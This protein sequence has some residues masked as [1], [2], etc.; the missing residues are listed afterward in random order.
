MPEPLPR[1]PFRLEAGARQIAHDVDAELEFHLAMRTRQLIAAGLDP[2]AARAQAE[3]LFGNLPAVRAQCLTIDHAWER[4]VTRANQLDNLRQDATH[5][6]RGLRHHPGFAAVLLLI[7]ALGIGA[8]T[9]MFSLIDVLMRRSLPVPRPAQLVGVGDQRR[10]G[11]LSTG[12]PRTDL[13]S[14]PLYRDLR[15]RNRVVTGLYA[16]GRTGGL[17]VVIAPL[18]GGSTAGAEPEHPRGRL[19]SGNF[20]SVLQVPAQ[21]GRTFTADEDQSPLSDPVVV[22][23]Y[24]YWQRRFGGEPGVLGRRLTINGAPLTIIGV[25][26]AGFTGDLVGQPTDIWIPLMMQPAIMPHTTWLTDRS[27]GWLLLMGRLAPGV[28]LPQARAELRRLAGLSIKENASAADLPSIERDLVAR[29]VPVESGARGFSYYRSQ[30]A[31][32]LLTLLS[33]VG[34]VLLVVCANVATMM[35]ARAEGRSREMSVRMALGAGRRRLVQQMLTESVILAAAGGALGLVVALW[36]SAALLRLAGGGT[37]IPLD[38]RLDGRM[39]GITAMLSLLTAVLFGLAPALRAT[40]IEVATALRAQGRGVAGA[41]SRPGRIAFGKL[42]VMSQVALSLLLLV[43]TGMLLRSL[44]RLEHTDVGLAR[45]SLVIARVDAERA[46]YA[47]PRLLALLRDLPGQVSQVPGVAGVSM[48]ENGIFSGTESSTTLQVEGFVARVPEDTAANY[49]DVGPGYF[50]TVGAHLLSG[51]DFAVQDN[52]SGP[53]VAVVNQTMARFYFPAGG[54]LGR[55]VTV[56]SSSFEIVGV[57]ADILGRD[58]RAEPTRRLYLPAAQ[59]KQPPSVFY[60][61]IRT[62][63]DPA[64][65]IEPIRRAL[66]R[67]DPALVVLSVDPLS[68]LVRGSIGRDRMVARVVSFFGGLTLLLAGLGLYGVMAYATARRTSEF[69]LRMALGAESGRLARM[70]LREA[71]LLVGGG[72]ALGLPLALAATRL[73]KAQLFGVRLLD[74]PSIALAIGV[75][76]ASAVLAG[77][78]PAL[79]AAR[80][81][82]LEAIRAE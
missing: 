59:L 10:T 46:G 36:G 33:A 63:G 67:A 13:F 78:L 20:F 71:L 21:L 37:G 53:R 62:T 57:V 43:G 18:D 76:V 2:V 35:L 65:S 60:L 50:R 64:R 38:I 4:S 29:P 23:S 40:R 31:E 6:L 82:P 81:A 74:L 69:G 24:G 7:L 44:Q 26:P 30:Y 1:Q 41:G 34:V 12:S 73:L 47:G 42:L 32:A 25:T 5:A 22:L 61:Q 8:N 9:A 16:T 72:L 66:R 14:V 19:V 55:R 54:A 27:V 79:R 45:D 17:D 15:D 80:V 11:S 51:R 75:L 52:E 68:A 39:L 48:S 70:I 28:T 49:D 56:D 77:W 3:Q 58:L